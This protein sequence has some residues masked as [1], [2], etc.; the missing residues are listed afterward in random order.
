MNEHQ[1]GFAL[2]ENPADRDRLAELGQIA[3]GLVHELKNP[4]GAIDLNTQLLQNQIQGKDLTQV[5]TDKV[6]TR[7]NRIHEG[8]KH[9]ANIIGSFLNY[10]RPGKPDPDR[11]DIN[12]VLQSILGQH[13]ELFE[14]AHVEASFKPQDDLYAVPADRN[15]LSSA[16]LNIILNGYEALQCKDGERH[17]MIVTRNR[18]NGISIIIANNGPALSEN[19]ANH[20]FDAFYSTKEHGTGLGLAIT[21]RLLELHHGKVSVHSDPAQ[22]VSFTIDLPTELG[23]AKNRNELPEPSVTVEAVVRDDDSLSNS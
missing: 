23:P 5:N 22:G 11:V 6:S 19:A 10:A 2:P 13:Q 12:D 14:Q 3:S 7:L 18:P 20:L 16:F 8:T 9:M 4:L 17:L 1:Y 21:Q 15:Q